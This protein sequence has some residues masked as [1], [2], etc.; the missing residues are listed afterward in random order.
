MRDHFWFRA[1]RKYKLA[2]IPRQFAAIAALVTFTQCLAACQTVAYYTQAARGQTE[3]WL[4]SRSVNRLLTRQE[5]PQALRRDLERSVAVLEFAGTVI[6]LDDGGNYRKYADLERDAVVHN[7]IAAP[8]HSLEPKQWCYPVVGCVPYRGYF[9]LAAARAERAR[10]EADGWETYLGRVPAYSTLGWFRDP[11][12]NTFV[13]W[14]DGHFANLLI[15]ELSHGRVWVPDDAAFNESFANFVGHQGAVQWLRSDNPSLADGA[16]ERYLRERRENQQFRKQ[17]ELL[18]DRL[19]A[20]YAQPGPDVDARK[21]AAI[22]SFAA[23]YESNR[24]SFRGRY[25][26]V[27][28]RDIN[29]AYLAARGTYERFEPAFAA[30]FAASG[31]R[32]PTFFERVDAL[33]KL[34]KT[35]RH[36]RLRELAEQHE[37]E[38]RDGDDTQQVECKALTHHAA[39]GELS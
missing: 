32:W 9:R 14:A 1:E 28:A 13:S 29:N 20:I 30:L 27:V 8:A 38:A 12:L 31:E 34:D 24:A 17:T 21:Q 39:D 26:R 19:A 2:S 36:Q 35:A 22:A 33:T 4:K 3:I 25:D 15:H 11:L 7:V 10:L 37:A 6:G 16:Y 18:R 5:V 23:C